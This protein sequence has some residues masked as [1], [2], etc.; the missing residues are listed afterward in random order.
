[1]YLTVVLFRQGWKTGPDEEGYVGAPCCHGFGS[2][3]YENTKLRFIVIDRLG[4]DLEKYF[5]SGDLPMPLVTV[6]RIGM[7]VLDTLEFIHAQN[8]VHNDI[9]AQNLLTGAEATDRIFLVDF[10]LACKYR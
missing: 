5:K 2:L 10:G 3:H 6:L 9:K 8:Y 1:M 7:E 4:S